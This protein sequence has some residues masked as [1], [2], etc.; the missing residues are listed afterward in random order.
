MRLPCRHIFAVRADLDLELFD[1]LE[2]LC[3]RRWSID[4]FMSSQR[5]F[6]SNEAVDLL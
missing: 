2:T 5:V 6:L 3:D 1:D 4:Y